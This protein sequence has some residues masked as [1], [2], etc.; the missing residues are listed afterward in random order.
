MK[1][2]H[3]DS[4]AYC[5]PRFFPWEFHKLPPQSATLKVSESGQPAA[6]T[7]CCRAMISVPLN[8][9]MVLLWAGCMGPAFAPKGGHGA[10]LISSAQRAG[11]SPKGR[12]HQSSPRVHLARCWHRG[13]LE[14][15][16]LWEVRSL[17]SLVQAV[18]EKAGLIRVPLGYSWPGAYGYGYPY[19]K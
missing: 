18:G 11:C 5:A 1:C 19:G 17:G 13:W 2:L 15:V 7:S 6:C 3:Q 12:P 8:S 4:S 10:V 16:K 14:G 9:C